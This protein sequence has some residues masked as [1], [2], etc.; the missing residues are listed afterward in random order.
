MNSGSSRATARLISAG[1]LT[2]WIV[3]AIA[4]LLR[5]DVN[6]IEDYERAENDISPVACDSAPSVRGESAEP[7]RYQHSRG[8]PTTAANRLAACRRRAKEA[9]GDDR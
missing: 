3:G 5:R 9:N 4:H 1:G 8:R 2:D 6:Q 7:P